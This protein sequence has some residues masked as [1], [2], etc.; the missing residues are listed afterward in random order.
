MKN[1]KLTLLAEPAVVTAARFMKTVMKAYEVE[2]P[3]NL[4]KDGQFDIPKAIRPIEET[5]GGL[6]WLT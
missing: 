4:E 6:T 3:K 5:L 2:P 1:R